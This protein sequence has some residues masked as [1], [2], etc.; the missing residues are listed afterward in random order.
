MPGLLSEPETRLQ[1]PGV[2]PA[3]SITTRPLSGTRQPGSRAQALYTARGAGP[4]ACTPV[5]GEER[6]E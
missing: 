5:R 1:T 3:S 2:A 4:Q 6:Q